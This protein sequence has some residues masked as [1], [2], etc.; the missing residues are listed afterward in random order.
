MNTLYL[1][2]EE[3]LQELKKNLNHKKATYRF[4]EQELRPLSNEVLCTEQI[5]YHNKSIYLLKDYQNEKSFADKMAIRLYQDRFN[6]RLSPANI[7][8]GETL[9]EEQRQATVIECCIC[10]Y[11]PLL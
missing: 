10:L 2:P 5:A 11:Q 9:S 1:T 6:R 7:K 3:F 8:N 4:S